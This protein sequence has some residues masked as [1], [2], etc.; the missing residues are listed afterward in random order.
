MTL[1]S[2]VTMHP[3][4]KVLTNLRT[5]LLILIIVGGFLKFYKIEITLIRKK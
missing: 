5:L 4:F 2:L 3:V 1:F